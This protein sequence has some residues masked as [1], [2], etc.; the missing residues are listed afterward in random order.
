[1]P[2]APMFRPRTGS[3]RTIRSAAAAASEIAGRRTTR[4]TTAL[5]NRL[6]SPALSATRRPTNGTWSRSIRSPR[7]LKIAGSRVSAAITETIPTRIAPDGEA[8]HDRALDEQEPEHRQDEGAAA[9]EHGAACGRAR[10]GDR[11]VLLR[12][13]GPLL[14][15][16]RDDEERV[17][18][19]ERETHA[20]EHVHDEDRKLE[21]LR[22][23]G[24]QAERD[25]D[26]DDREHERHRR[27]D[28]RP[29][30]ED[31]DDER[32][33]QPDPELPVLEVALRELVD[34]VV[35]RLGARHRDLESAPAV[36]LLDRLDDVD[37]RLLRIAF[38]LDRD[39]DGVPIRRDEALVLERI[40]RGRDGAGRSGDLDQL[41]EPGHELW[42]VDGELR[43]ADDDELGRQVVEP[44]GEELALEVVADLGLRVVRHLGVG[45]QRASEEAS[46]RDKGE[47]AED[48]PDGDR[49][50]R[51]QRARS[52]QPLGHAGK[53]ALTNQDVK[54]T[55][56][57]TIGAW[58]R[59]ERSRV[60]SVRNHQESARGG[61]RGR[62]S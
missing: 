15:E 41:A 11:V 44:L 30:D 56:V 25:D 4:L 9:E 45:G 18:D 20:G 54:P 33:R 49:P 8:P 3:A 5:Q 46:D 34:V 2:A 19:P 32:G 59:L 31:E 16:A 7:R 40:P 48:E 14:A 43:R 27:A 21:P 37:D 10:A 23:E 26:R 22:E 35:G 6:S 47:S 60:A 39:Q 24:G 29:E 1:M 52:S 42:I 55:R 61:P 51:T 62:A 38:E 57:V 17:V 12:S 50:P 36:F 13:R 53:L 58:H 28:E